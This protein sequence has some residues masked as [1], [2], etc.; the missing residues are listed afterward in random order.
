MKLINKRICAGV[1]SLAITAAFLNSMPI[2]SRKD[3]NIYAK[4]A[5]SNKS[6]AIYGDVNSDDVIDVFDLILARETVIGEEYIKEADLDGDK[7]LD[8]DDI[9]YLEGFLLGKTKSFPIYNNFDEDSD[10]VS[11]YL[12]VEVFETNFRNDDTDK[13]GLSD[14]FEIYL[15]ESDP[16]VDG[17][18]VLEDP[19]EDN[20]INR[21]ESIAL[22]DPFSDDTDKDNISD[23]DE[24]KKYGT[25][26]LDDD[27]DDDD[28]TDA[29][30][31][32]LNLDPLND[33]T[34]GVPDGERI[35]EQVVEAD[36]PI[37]SEINTEENAYNLSLIVNAS[38]CVD[39][40]LEVVSSGYSYIMK[41]GSAI[42]EVPEFI[43]D[44][45]Y[46][47]EDI[48][49]KFEI[50]EDFRESVIDL[51][52]ESYSV[53]AD[54]ELSGIKRLNIFK[55]FE[56]IN[57]VMPIETQYD[58][59][60]NIV[61]VTISKDN[62]EINEETG[63]YEIGSYSLVDL[64]VWAA[65]MNES[66]EETETVA[67][68][69]DIDGNVLRTAEVNILSD[70]KKSGFKDRAE[71]TLK[72]IFKNYA[73]RL[74]NSF[75]EEAGEY[76]SANVVT[77]GGHKYAIIN[78]RCSW[79][80]AEKEC[81][82]LGGHLM[83]LNNSFEFSFL[84]SALTSGTTK[85]HYWL[86]AYYSS[87][88]WKW[89]DT[90]QRADFLYSLSKTISGYKAT[91]RDYYTYVGSQFYY[92]DGMS[93]SRNSSLEAGAFICEWDSNNAYNRGRTNFSG[94]VL[95]SAGMHR[96]VLKSVLTKGSKTDTD[97]DG[98]PDYDELD[99]KSIEKIG[100]K[101][102]T[103][104]S[105]LQEYNYI[106]NNKVST[107][108]KKWES[109]NKISKVL[110]DSTSITIEYPKIETDPTTKDT[111]GDYYIDPL[112]KDI[113]KTNPMVIPVE[114]IDDSWML[115]YYPFVI[116]MNLPPKP[117]TDLYDR[118][119]KVLEKYPEG[120]AVYSVKEN[121]IEDGY[122][123]KG[124]LSYYRDITVNKKSEF[125]L[126]IDKP[127]DFKI[128]MTFDNSEDVNAILNNEDFL[129]IKTKKS[130]I[131][132]AAYKYVT[133]NEENISSN[134]IEYNFAIG[135]GIDYI[136]TINNSLLSSN[137]NFTIYQDNWVYAPNGGIRTGVIEPHSNLKVIETYFTA[138]V[139]YKIMCGHRQK[140]GFPP[141][142]N[143]YD[144][145]LNDEF[146]LNYVNRES[147]REFA[148]FVAKGLEIGFENKNAILEFLE[149]NGELKNGVGYVVMLV[150]G[151][152][153]FV[154]KAP[155]GFIPIVGDI[156]D[157]VDIMESVITI[158]EK[159][160]LAD[161]KELEE[162]LKTG[163]LNVCVSSRSSVMLENYPPTFSAWNEPTKN[164]WKELRYINRYY[165]GYND[166]NI[167]DMG[168]E[169]RR[170]GEIIAFTEEMKNVKK[171][172]EEWTFYD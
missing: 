163:K 90:A 165:R 109:N 153:N 76:S 88:E 27:S 58:V 48:T 86:G 103:Q 119:P 65:L 124:Q 64:E 141:Y 147:V 49:L 30:E 46:N 128:I 71:K 106:C 34:N 116:D 38:G 152:Y 19:D 125:K 138:D 26:P 122:L 91:I 89:V 164:N 172:G 95:V 98:I 159:C 96:Y 20:L 115:E 69:S 101:G 18:E 83:T 107:L 97:N 9:Y 162:A 22:T 170:S 41:D 13:D 148:P 37:L 142:G 80:E 60:N 7:D 127:S 87:G 6:D 120:D 29:D 99:L 51:Y 134:A 144:A 156:L 114:Y 4:A 104:V 112:D 117:P 14:Y 45:K 169:Y 167:L 36:N 15:L 57:S 154:E 17:K 16:K 145:P 171:D 143:S 100:G 133:L 85:N 66:C 121:N 3:A 59:D 5:E 44:E 50:K 84:Q 12:E 11:D 146:I 8:E 130:I 94:G 56:E 149:K 102:A 113:K 54:E 68:I 140:T 136:I 135:S 42:G 43:Y 129:T 62:F 55:Y 47:I 151:A 31:I 73:S 1:I 139:V 32:K 126:N 161:I 67:E 33:A 40:C 79:E 75:H 81:E 110:G 61:Y 21:D 123:T 93:Y 82:R 157:G 24:V 132:G 108:V 72:A 118:Q 111:D 137:F 2:T 39:S 35:I 63:S 158:G 74:I 155:T 10:G 168:W 52:A 77:L 70:E 92:A 78:K 160:K 28:L 25:K 150:E 105:W 131:P 23:Y 53:A 166:S